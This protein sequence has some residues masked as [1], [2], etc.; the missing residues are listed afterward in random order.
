MNQRFVLGMLLAFVFTAFTQCTVQKRV[1]RKGYYISFHQQRKH[2]D[3]DKNQKQLATIPA[4][5]SLGVK[6][7]LVS[8]ETASSI[9]ELQLTTDSVTNKLT[10]NPVVHQLKTT[11]DVLKN[12]YVKHREAMVQPARFYKKKANEEIDPTVGF[13]MVLAG[14]FHRFYACAPFHFTH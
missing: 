14:A 1:Y 12:T 2:V 6:P 8:S 4:L 9:I 10:E 3:T 7:E 13:F 5:D 11:V